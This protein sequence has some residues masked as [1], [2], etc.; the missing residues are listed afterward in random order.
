[1][2]IIIYRPILHQLK[3]RNRTDMTFRGL[4]FTEI[5][6]ASQSEE[7]KEAITALVVPP[8]PPEHSCVSWESFLISVRCHWPSGKSAETN[9]DRIQSWRPVDSAE[10]TMTLWGEGA[11]GGVG[12]SSEDSPCVFWLVAGIDRS[13]YC[14]FRRKNVLAYHTNNH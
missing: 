2:E 11:H 9:D 12:Q 6:T 13:S 1:M 8:L 5:V 3:H 10:N 4:I 14:C 7:S